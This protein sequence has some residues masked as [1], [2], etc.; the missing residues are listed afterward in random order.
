MKF[1]L[2]FALITGA[3]FSWAQ[4]STI[5][6]TLDGES[7]K[8]EQVVIPQDAAG[9]H[10]LVGLAFSKKSEEYLNG[11]FGPIYDQ[12]IKKPE[13]GSLFAFSYDVQVYFV[14]MITG[15]KRPAYEKVMK[16]VEK[17]VDKKLHPNV[18]FYKGTMSDYKERLK[19]DDKDLPY[20]FLL[21]PE[22]K[23]IYS[24]KGMYNAAKLQKIVDRLPFE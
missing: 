4:T 17:D 10:T 1:L 5:F 8:H 6:P 3:L 15:A 18:L 9:Q 7:L 24:T 22:G 19:I 11:W 2:Y 13:A 16:K 20:F 12:L 14:P 23:I 21:D